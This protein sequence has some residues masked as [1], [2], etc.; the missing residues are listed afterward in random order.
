MDNHEK[1]VQKVML[2][3]MEKVISPHIGVIYVHHE[4]EK[5]LPNEEQRWKLHIVIDDKTTIS[6]MRKAWI[7]I[8][9]ARDNLM[10]YQGQEPNLFSTMIFKFIDDYKFTGIKD[11]YFSKIMNFLS[12]VY[13][14][15]E[16]KEEASVKN[17][18]TMNG[19]FYSLLRTFQIKKPNVQIWKDNGRNKLLKNQL[20]WDLTHGPITVRRVIDTLISFKEQQENQIFIFHN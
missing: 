2:G 6:E 13:L 9:M 1:I 11:S 12:L 16:I 20:P 19:Y 8:L 18:I 5:F 17:E 10:E 4:F 3:I 15:R 14:I 7:D